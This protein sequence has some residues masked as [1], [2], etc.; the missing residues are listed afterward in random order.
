[1]SRKITVSLLVTLAL[2]AGCSTDGTTSQQSSHFN[3]S[4]GESGYALFRNYVSNLSRKPTLLWRIQA[5]PEQT[6]QAVL[7]S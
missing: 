6:F 5:S 7:A 2:L 3:Q 1:M 4:F